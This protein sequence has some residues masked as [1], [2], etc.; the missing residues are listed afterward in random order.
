[1]YRHIPVIVD[2]TVPERDRIHNLLLLWSEY[3]IHTDDS[4][5]PL[6]ELGFNS[7]VPWADLVIRE[8][9]YRSRT[10]IPITFDE[11]YAVNQVVRQ[12]AEVIQDALLMEYCGIGPRYRKAAQ[13]GITEK[14][15]R[16][17]LEEGFTILWKSKVWL[18]GAHKYLENDLK[19][20]HYAKLSLNSGSKC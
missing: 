1:M 5:N 10:L 18:G 8:R 15:F 14:T 17:R 7:C 2:L 4:G 19:L 9:V 20:V 16:R 3:L 6:A 12:M 11:Y 13:L